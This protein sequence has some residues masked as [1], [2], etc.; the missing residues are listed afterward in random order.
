MRLQRGVW[1]LAIAIATIASSTMPAAAER[2][3]Q[4]DTKAYQNYVLNCMGCHGAAG[5]GVPG[6]IPPLKGAVGLFVHT[7]AGR[8][9][10][11]RVPGASTSLLTDAELA[12]VT[13]MML[14]RF[15]AGQAPA[16]FRPYTAEEVAAHRRPAYKDVATVRRAVIEG[17]RRQG[18]P[19]RL[20]Y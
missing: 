14:A 11:I 16:D 15:G 2:H 20:D 12:A 19:M 8:E 5:D 10:I 4:E 6:K 17:L 3:S 7:E 9:F 18:I 1:R 13:N